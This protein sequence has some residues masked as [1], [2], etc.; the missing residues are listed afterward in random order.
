[1]RFKGIKKHEKKIFCFFVVDRRRLYFDKNE[2]RLHNWKQK[3]NLQ[4]ILLQRKNGY[5]IFWLLFLFFKYF[6]I[7]S[8][9][10]YE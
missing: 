7:Y 2:M 9:F 1:M 6:D 4:K 8:S 10:S 5:I 3:Q